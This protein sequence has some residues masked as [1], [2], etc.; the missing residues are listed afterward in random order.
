[1]HGHIEIIVTQ[2]LPHEKSQALQ[3]TWSPAENIRQAKQTFLSH[4]KLSQ[5]EKNI[6]E[7]NK[8]LTKTSKLH[9]KN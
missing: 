1:M 8:Q 5:L 9:L 6:N 2:F 7:N 4:Y 3:M